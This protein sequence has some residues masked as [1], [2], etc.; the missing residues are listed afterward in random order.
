[1]AIMFGN[2]KVDTT[3]TTQ[4]KKTITFT[5]SAA[6]TAGAP[7]TWTDANGVAQTIPSGVVY[8]DESG[9]TVE[10]TSIKQSAKYFATFDVPVSGQTI[11]VGP[12]TFP[13][14][15]TNRASRREVKYSRNNFVNCWKTAA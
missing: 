13:G 11:V 3:S 5:A 10:G 14:T 9:T 12:N 4:I 8:T 1:M 7:K 2:G 6:G 15:L